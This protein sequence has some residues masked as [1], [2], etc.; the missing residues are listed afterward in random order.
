M[1]IENIHWSNFVIL[2]LKMTGDLI[3]T[4]LEYITTISHQNITTP[5]T[6]FISTNSKNSNPLHKQKQKIAVYCSSHKNNKNN[7]SNSKH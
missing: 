2:R 7:K 3:Q 6:Q 5:I 4:S 1:T